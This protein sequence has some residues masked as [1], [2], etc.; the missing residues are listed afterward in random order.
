MSGSVSVDPRG[1]WHLALGVR[2]STKGQT[3]VMPSPLA[4][5]RDLVAELKSMGDGSIFC[6]D[7]GDE[8][9]CG[10]AVSTSSCGLQD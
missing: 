6:A 8:V 9:P 3:V 7:H 5:L 2:I 4:V 10:C 1:R